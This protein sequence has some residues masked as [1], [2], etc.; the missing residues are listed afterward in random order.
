MVR[1]DMSEYQE[2]SS[3]SRLLGAAPGYAGNAGGG[4]LTGAVRQNPFAL[5]LLDE[6]EKAHPDILNVFLQ[7]MDDGRLTDSQPHD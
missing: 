2:P 5:V 6:I 3:L 7:V 1:L 4:Y